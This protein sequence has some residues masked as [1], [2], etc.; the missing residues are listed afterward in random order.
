MKILLVTDAW[1]PQVN[2]VVRTLQQTSEAMRAAGHDVVVL[3]PAGR[4]TL[5]CPSYPE[6]RLT[7][8][9][10]R[11][12]RRCFAEHGN[13]DAIHVATE[14]PLGFAVR[15]YCKRNGLRFTTSYHTRFPE[16]LRMRAPVPLRLSYAVMRGFHTAAARTFVRTATQ[17]RL[18][19]E[20]GFTNLEIW[21]GAVD[22]QLFRP[23]EK[24]ALDLPRPI[25][26]YMGRVAPE[27]NIEAFLDLK[28]PGSRVIVGGGPALE[29]LKRRYPDVHFIGY[30]HGE[31]L[32]ET[33]AAADVFVFPSLT[34]TLGLVILEA[35][36]CGVP[37]AGFPVPGPLDLIN[38]GGNGAIDENLGEAV[39]RALAVQPEDCVDFASQFSWSRSTAHLLSRLVPACSDDN[40]RQPGSPP[41]NSEQCPSLLQAPKPASTNPAS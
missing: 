28:L 8:R 35:M 29:S 27:K 36:A 37:V 10:F 40:E 13:F 25:S 6:I 23:R 22:T 20:K 24:D 16:Y 15:R 21:H 31:A 2:G 5:P 4:R 34:D 30:R 39:F 17:K 38:D 1:A 11:A 32:A 12:T 3:S 7:L 18:L 33:L 26:M 19:A 41:Y 9:P 14:G